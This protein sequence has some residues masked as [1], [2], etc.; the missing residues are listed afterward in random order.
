MTASDGWHND[1]A[2]VRVGLI[3]IND[4]DPRFRFPQ[5][6]FYV[7]PGAGPGHTVRLANWDTH[8]SAPLQVGRVHVYDGDSGD[9]VTLQLR[10][11]FARVFSVTQQGEIV[12][13]QPGRM[14]GTEAHI[15]VVAEV[16]LNQANK[17]CDLVRYKSAEFSVAYNVV[18]KLEG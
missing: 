9:C 7:S 13:T 16:R 14:N 12:L 3:N 15:V 2:Q 17:I 5:Y 10:G 18:I 8:T 6:E 4:W 11:A 1:T